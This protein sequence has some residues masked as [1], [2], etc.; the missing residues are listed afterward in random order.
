[1]LEWLNSLIEWLLENGKLFVSHPLVFIT[2]ALIE[3]A[4]LIGLLRLL[5]G[6][7][8]KELPNLSEIKDKLRASQEDTFRLSEENKRL[9]AENEM[10][11]MEVRA[12]QSDK[13]LLIGMESGQ[14]VKSM[15]KK[16]SEVLSS[17]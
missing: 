12:L 16:I 9:H 3:A 1:M 4:I 17:H 8:L 6:D 2:F 15:G 13:D 10:L 7:K 14:S 11:Q 5:Y